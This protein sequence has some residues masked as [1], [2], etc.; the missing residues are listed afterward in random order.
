MNEIFLILISLVIGAALGGF[1]FLIARS[2]KPETQEEI[3]R[4]AERVEMA[5][6]IWSE[7]FKEVRN[8]IGKARHEELELRD[9]SNKDI[10]HQMEKFIAGIVQ[11]KEVLNQ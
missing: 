11:M 2:K 1:I 5:N 10:H 3:A 9:R 8:E 6:K 4:L 7:Q